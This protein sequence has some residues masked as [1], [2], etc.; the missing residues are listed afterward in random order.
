MIIYLVGFMGSGKSTLGRQLAK[1]LNYKF[2]DLDALFV[3]KTK[4]K[5]HEFFEKYGEDAFRKSEYELLREIDLS[6]NLVIATGGGT[7]CFMDNMDYMRK[8]GITVFLQL[9]ATLLCKRLINSHT[10]RPMVI[11]K[12]KEELEIWA[13]EMIKKRAGFYKKAHVIIDAR[14]LSTALLTKVLNPYISDT[15]SS[16]NL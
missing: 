9:E 15:I 13:D 2:I 3:S 4:I 5:I 14:N 6:N 12:T 8:T 11:G 10:I 7:P 16:E 1:H